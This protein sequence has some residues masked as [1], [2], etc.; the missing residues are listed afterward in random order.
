MRVGAVAALNAM[1]CS[2]LLTAVLA[3]LVAGSLRFAIDTARG[4]RPAFGQL[5]CAVKYRLDERHVFREPV[6]C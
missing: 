4:C 2:H 1:H 6:A 5:G 3:W